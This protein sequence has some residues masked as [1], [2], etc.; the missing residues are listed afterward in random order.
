MAPA[1]RLRMAGAKG[2]DRP[3][4]NL[5]IGRPQMLRV[6]VQAF[7][8]GQPCNLLYL[9]AGIRHIFAHGKPTPNSG[10]GTTEPVK[11]IADVLCEFLFRT[12]DGEFTR[13]LR[14]HG[15]AV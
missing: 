9:P 6:Q 11:Q 15:F 8:D 1:A 2:Y 14:D 5:A 13:R 12:M 4:H 3:T 7:L 10:A